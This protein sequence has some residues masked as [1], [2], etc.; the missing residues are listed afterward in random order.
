MVYRNRISGEYVGLVAGE[1]LRFLDDNDVG[2]T[3]D[4]HRLVGIKSNRNQ[5]GDFIS[6]ELRPSMHTQTL[7][8]S[9]VSRGVGVP[10]E[11]KFNEVFG[12]SHI[13]LK[14]DYLPLGYR[15]FARD[16]FGN[17]IYN[18]VIRSSELGGVKE[19]LKKLA[20]AIE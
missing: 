17:G 9:Y 1:L 10:L 7:T 16:A 14:G 13:I 6:V 18:K 19:D 8:L 5:I 20:L 11:V 2:T 15:L 4:L 3:A 12:Y